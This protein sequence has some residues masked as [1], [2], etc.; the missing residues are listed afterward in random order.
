VQDRASPLLRL[1]YLLPVPVLRPLPSPLS[2][3]AAVLLGVLF[4]GHLKQFRM[5]S[6]AHALPQHWPPQWRSSPARHDMWPSQR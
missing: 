2:V 1:L 4:L 6:A 3:P 5:C